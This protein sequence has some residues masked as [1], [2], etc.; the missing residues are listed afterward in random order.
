MLTLDRA[1]PAA[2]HWTELQYLQFFQ[3]GP[4]AAERLVLIAESISEASTEDTASKV[5]GFLVAKRIADEWEL[6]NIVVA[7]EARRKGFGKRLLEALL[8]AA[9]QTNGRAVFLEVRESNLAARGFYER[10]GFHESG[11]RKLYYSN[12]SENAVLYRWD[13]PSCA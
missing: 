6:E 10:M 12:P 9:R 5:V 8:A 1:S 13:R 11:R 2:A 7:E 4:E 3:S